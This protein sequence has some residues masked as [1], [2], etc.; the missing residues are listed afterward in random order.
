MNSLGLYT[1]GFETYQ[2]SASTGLSEDQLERAASTLI[3]YFNS[4]AGSPQMVVTHANGSQFD[5]FHDYELIHLADV[6]ILFAINAALQA[7]SLLLVVVFALAGFSFGRRDDVYKGLRYGAAATL[8]LLVT[9]AVAFLTNFNQ[10]FVAFHLVAFDN[11][12]WQLN[13]LTDYLV[14]LFPLGFWQDMFLIAG[15]STGLGAIATYASVT[16]ATRASRR[17]PRRRAVPNQRKR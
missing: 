12:F 5:L 17:T 6:R 15:A 10:M 11:P 16:L 9:S 1:R 14:M 2:V 13:P 3:L 8:A 4:L 7:I